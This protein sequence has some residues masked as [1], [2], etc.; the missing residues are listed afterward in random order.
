VKQSGSS[1]DRYSIK[2]IQVDRTISS[3][4]FPFIPFPFFRFPSFRGSLQIDR[5]TNRP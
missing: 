5:Q 1:V 3:S 4:A 2:L